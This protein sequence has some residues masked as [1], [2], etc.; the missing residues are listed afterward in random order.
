MTENTTAGNKATATKRAASS[1]GLPDYAM[2]KFAMPKF[3]LPNME[4]PHAF[5]EM[6]GQGVEHARDACAKAKVASEEAAALL[7]KTYVTVARGVTDYN[8]KLIEIAGINARAA[9]DRAYELLGA[10]SPSE[11]FELSTIQMRKQFDVASAQNKELC[12]LAQETANEAA[13]PIKAG[14]SKAFNK[15]A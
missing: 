3:E 14:V 1:F 6:A 7:E 2:P 9:F 12:A 13:E 10:K 15:A 8:R 11:F 5:R 4:M